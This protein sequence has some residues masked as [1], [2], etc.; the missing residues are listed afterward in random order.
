MTHDPLCPTVRPFTVIIDHKP[1][2]GYTL[3]HCCCALLAEARREEQ[4]RKGTCWRE[5]PGANIP[6][7]AIRVYREAGWFWEMSQ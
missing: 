7:N 2:T 1:M 5:M 4:K 3:N 6:A